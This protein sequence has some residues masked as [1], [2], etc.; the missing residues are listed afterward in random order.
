MTFRGPIQKYI[1]NTNILIAT[2]V[3]E[4]LEFQLLANKVIP[5]V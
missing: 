3:F 5:R 4:R 1:V 2:I